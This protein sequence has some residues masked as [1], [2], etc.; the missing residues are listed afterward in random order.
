MIDVVN[1]TEAAQ[2]GLKL[3]VDYDQA[4]LKPEAATKGIPA[5]GELI[6]DVPTLLPG[7]TQRFRIQCRCL[8][9]GRACTIATVTS[10][11]GPK[12]AQ[13]ACVVISTAGGQA[14]APNESVPAESG[15]ALS[16]SPA[17]A[18]LEPRQPSRV[19]VTVAEQSDPVRV[20][21]E[22]TYF[23]TVKN[24]ASYADRQVL[25]KVAIPAELQLISGSGPTRNRISGQ[26]ITFDPI[27]ELRAGEQVEY[28][29]RVKAAAAGTAR[30]DAAVSS[31]GLVQPILKSETTMVVSN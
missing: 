13:E 22:I 25:L 24:P 26:T 20:G 28:R 11:G 31:Q 18:S 8:A 12:V 17:A 3:S 16:A 1:T 29:L 23:V 5:T 7:Q 14:A 21:S 2:Q 30:L 10:T 6:W 19:T 27:A 9:A 4:L 15:P